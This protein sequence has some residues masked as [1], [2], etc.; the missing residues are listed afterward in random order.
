[1]TGLWPHR[2]GAE[3]FEPIR[4]GIGVIN[5][6]LKQTGYK[7]G[8]LGKVGHIQ[9]VERFGWDMAADMRQLGLGRNP[10]AYG[11]PPKTSLPTLR[12]MAAPVPHG[13]CPR[14]PPA[15]PRQPG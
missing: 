14:S 15:L 7:V 12:M 8:I 5:D 9:P 6:H 10:D 11:S 4:E 3:G 2:N 13:Q 1:M